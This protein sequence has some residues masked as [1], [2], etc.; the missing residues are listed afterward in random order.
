MNIGVDIKK[1]LICNSIYHFKL[2]EMALI[3]GEIKQ[4]YTIN[5]RDVIFIG[6]FC[7][8][9]NKFCKANYGSFVREK[10]IFIKLI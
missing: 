1:G 4:I 2:G 10:N 6:Q 9:I 3:N 5:R 8:S 7:I